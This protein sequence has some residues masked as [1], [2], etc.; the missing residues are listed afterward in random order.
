MT[1][2]AGASHVSIATGD[3]ENKTI[4]TLNFAPLHING[5]QN[6]GELITNFAKVLF[7]TITDDRVT[8]KTGIA[9]IFNELDE[10]MRAG[11]VPVT[12]IVLLEQTY[13]DLT[14]RMLRDDLPEQ[15]VDR[16]ASAFQLALDL[17]YVRS[18]HR[19]PSD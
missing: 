16:Y 9:D 19:A 14:G 1:V 12:S 3:E 4:P 5:I 8:D 17:M 10:L 6:M 15:Y 13:Q 2:F 18:I 7:D 11:S